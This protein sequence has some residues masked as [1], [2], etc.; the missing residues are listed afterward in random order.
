MFF[1][2]KKKN[3]GI[4]ENVLKILLKKDSLNQSGR[5]QSLNY[6]KSVRYF[7]QFLLF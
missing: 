1:L 6:L 3:I 5:K 4:T 7:K 2:F